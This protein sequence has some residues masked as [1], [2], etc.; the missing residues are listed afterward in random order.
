[1]TFWED[2]LSEILDENGVTASRQQVVA[3]AKAIQGAASVE[4][5][6]TGIVEQT[7]PGAP[8]KSPE[9][10]RIERLEEC[11]RRLGARF[12]VGIDPNLMEINYYTPVGT[13]HWGTTRETLRG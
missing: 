7:R 1:M 2:T 9:A 13:S 10:Q 12:G 8:Q 5:E 3:I 11:I 6:Y 4:A